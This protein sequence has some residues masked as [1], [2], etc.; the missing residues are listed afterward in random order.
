MFANGSDWSSF[1][2]TTSH[3]WGPMRG[4][5]MFM[6]AFL[7]G[8][9][10][11]GGRSNLIDGLDVGFFGKLNRRGDIVPKELAEFFNT[12]IF[13]LNSELGQFFPNGGIVKCFFSRVV[14]FLHNIGRCFCRCR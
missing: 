7:M 14:Q 5:L 13:W 3:G 10:T 6:R 1:V 12:D 4:G 9:R 11:V 8:D 2:R